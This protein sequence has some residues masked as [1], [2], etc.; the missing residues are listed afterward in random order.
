MGKDRTTLYR[1]PAEQRDRFVEALGPHAGK[2]TLWTLPILVQTKLFTD[3][4]FV[5]LTQRS[6]F[7]FQA[8]FPLIYARI[9]QLRGETKEA[10]QEYVDLRLLESATLMDKKTPMPRDV[11]EALDIYATYYLALAF[12]ERD[13]SKQAALFFERTLA[14]LPEYGPGRP[15]YNMLRWGAQSNLARL[16]EAEGHAS[17]GD[18]VLHRAQ[19]DVPGPRRPHPR[20]G[21]GLARSDRRGARC[22]P[23]GATG[24]CGPLRP[25]PGPV[26]IAC[27]F[28][29]RAA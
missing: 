15:Y 17:R 8:Q 9:K 24:G 20:P 10:I 16:E 27:A 28:N 2:V 11:Q 4:Q 19:A 3:A 26:S 12:L 14:L 18:R 25:D 6:L 29:L 21:A 22:T 1:D 23:P 13:D 7:L 5:E